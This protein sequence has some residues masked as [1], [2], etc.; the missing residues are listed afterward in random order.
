MEKAFNKYAQM[1]LD[2][3]DLTQEKGITASEAID[4]L[5]GAY[6]NIAERSFKA[7]QQAKSFNEAIDA[8]KDAVGSSWMKVF[9][10]FFGNKEEATETWTELA[11]RLYDIFVPSIDG[12]NERLKDGLNSGWNKLLENELGDQADVYAY[13][14]EQVALASGAITEKQISD[15]G[16]FGEAIKQGGISAELLK[17]GLGEAQSSAEKMLTLSD[18]ELEKRGTN[19]EE[20]EKNAQAFEELN[21]KVQ[22]GTLDLEAYSK[23]IRELSGREHLMQ[24]L[25]NLMDA[26][27]A[28]AKPIREAFQEIF[29]SKTGEEIKSFAQW[30]DSIT[31]KLIISDD[32]AKKIKT[33]AEGVFS[34]L[35]VGKDILEG[36]ISGMVR[37]LNLTKPLA[38]ILLDAASAA[39]EFS[40]EITKGLHPLETIG[41]WVTDFVNAAAPVLY[42]F[43]SAA[44]KI[45][46]Q[47]PKVR[48]M[49]STS[50]IPRS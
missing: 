33:T 16:S 8:T 47:S 12:L 4:E 34:A 25:W 49:R 29:P 5:S 7:A 50:L 46:T 22:N 21:K 32:T 44:D 9:E 14:M 27:T 24:S 15:A 48:R 39:G 17:K 11:N 28:I 31:K 41:T 42:S 6:D 45:F 3:Y 40:S 13:T 10:T 23:Q 26:A 1:T 35:R 20:V 30:L 37:V 18:A 36:I 19:R 2:V 43:G 38:D